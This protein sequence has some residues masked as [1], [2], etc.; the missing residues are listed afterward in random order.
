[1]REKEKKRGLTP[2]TLSRLFSCPPPPP[3]AARHARSLLLSL[4]LSS[5]ID[6]LTRSMLHSMKATKQAPTTHRRRATP[7]EAMSGG[8]GRP[9]PVAAAAAADSASEGGGGMEATRP[10]RGRRRVLASVRGGRGAGAVGP[11][12]PDGEAAGLRGGWA[13]G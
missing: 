7:V 1:M 6:M 8:A 2:S 13:R 9:D 11:G 5:P 3:A 4:S 12:R 10:V